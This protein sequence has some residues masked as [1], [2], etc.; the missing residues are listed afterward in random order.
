M[1]EGS[2]N[3]ETALLEAPIMEVDSDGNGNDIG[4]QEEVVPE[5]AWEKEI[6]GWAKGR[7]SLW[8]CIELRDR[9]FLDLCYLQDLDLGVVSRQLS[10]IFR[11]PST[12]ILGVVDASFSKIAQAWERDFEKKNTLC[13][14]HE[15]V[16]RYLVM[17]G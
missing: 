17:K 7:K 3:T 5:N 16:F 6:I 1:L 4:L 13:Q 9:N 2:R 11:V 14:E 10:H 8:K 12:Q 15:T